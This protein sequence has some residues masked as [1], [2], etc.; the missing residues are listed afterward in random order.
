MAWVLAAAV[1]AV[2]ADTDYEREV[3]AYKGWK[4]RGIEVRGLKRRTA[5]NLS[6]GLFLSTRPAFYE[7]ALEDDMARIKLFMARRGYPYTTVTP[8]F[9]PNEA[10]KDVKVTFNIDP[11]PAVIVREVSLTGVPEDLEAPAW[12]LVL[13]T[14]GSVFEDARVE[15]TKASL[16]SLFLYHGY[17][18]VDVVSDV[19]GLD[20]ASVRVSYDMR[21][22]RVNC[23]RDVAVKGAPD[24]LVALTEKVSDIWHGRRYST[25]AL[26]D[27]QDNLRRLDIYRR[28]VFDM[29]EVGEDSLDLT[30]NVA[31]RDPRTV[32]ATLRYW[33]DE[34]LRLGLSWRHRNLFRAGR[35]FY[36]A[37]VASRLLQRAEVSL[38]W[39]ALLAPRTK[40]EF[41]VGFERENE[42]AYEQVSYGI[43]VSSTYFFTIENNIQVSLQVGDVSVTYKN[44]DA[45]NLD[46]PQGFLAVLSTRANQNST[47]DPFNP[48][49]GFSSW[50]TLSW[51]PDGISQNA[52]IKWEGSASTY[53]GQVEPAVFALKLGLGLGTPLG[54]TPA[55]IPGTRFY[56]GGS[57]SMRG[58]ARRKLGPKD[59]EGAPL[60]GEAKLEASVEIR[61]PLFW[62]LWGTA[63]LDAG[64]V[65]SKVDEFD[66][67]EIELAAGPG[68]WIMTPVGPIRFDVG[69]R[70]TMRD[71]TEP[72]M[73]YHFAI[74]TAF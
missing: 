11:G 9:S 14:E 69:Y 21:A 40:E 34:G 71:V 25:K 67:S 35:G 16:D 24:D 73:V 42:E 3:M 44:P 49:R 15:A 61:G 64:Q 43:I 38:W 6:K 28:I 57:N 17:A 37:A 60:G 4:V 7:D 32:K 26:T 39:P 18:R 33:N 53:L 12:R 62:R 5:S 58:F 45:A 68:L 52:Y 23:F 1:G 74:G 50:S 10:W 13:T 63:F 46:V 51:G 65:W 55:L 29:A 36:T 27:A 47:D 41:S 70:L 20:T 59:S 30:I 22:G 56:S 2:R 72:R 19:A 54:D 48:R 66:L 31:E 8:A